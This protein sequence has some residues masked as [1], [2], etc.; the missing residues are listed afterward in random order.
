MKT[1]VYSALV[2]SILVPLSYSQLTW[3]SEIIQCL[4]HHSQINRLILI[5]DKSAPPY[6]HEI[7]RFVSELSPNFPIF[8]LFTN[9]EG[10]LAFLRYRC[11]YV[12]FYTL[13]I[14][15]VAITNK[16]TS[17][18][19]QFIITALFQGLHLHYRTVPNLIALVFYP[20]NISLENI[21]VGFNSTIK[22]LSQTF[23]DPH[24][25][26]LA[27]AATDDS[28]RNSILQSKTQS[29]AKMHIINVF[30]N[31]YTVNNISSVTEIF[32]KTIQNLHNTSLKLQVANLP[33]YLGVELSRERC[34]DPKTLSGPHGLILKSF[35]ESSNFTWQIFHNPGVLRGR[36]SSHINTKCIRKYGLED[37]LV[38]GNIH[39]YMFL[40]M[41]QPFRTHDKGSWFKDIVKTIGYVHVKRN[42][43]LVALVPVFRRKNVSLSENFATL[44]T[45]TVVI[46]IALRIIVYLMKF[47]SGFWRTS[48][49][50]YAIFGINV[51]DTTK[52]TA[53]RF[54]LC[55]MLIISILYSVAIIDQL[56]DVQMDLNREFKL[57]SWADFSEA[58][59]TFKTPILVKNMLLEIENLQ[60]KELLKK[61]VTGKQFRIM[62]KNYFEN[63][64][65]ICIDELMT[66]SYKNVSC[67]MRLSEA[68]SFVRL[69][70]IKYGKARVAVF[71]E[72]ILDMWWSIPVTPLPTY[73]RRFEEV[74]QYLTEAGLVEKWFETEL[75][76]LRDQYNTLNKID[77]NNNQTKSNTIVQLLA[78]LII[79]Y[80]ASLLFFLREILF[81]LTL[82]FQI[83]K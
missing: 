16:T 8:I 54:I 41:P 29:N 48:N 69:S 58:N 25:K 5:I 71:Q 56:F 38:R 14:Y 52:S 82:G 17:K 6:N 23:I 65:E 79:G 39:A 74:I 35:A 19:F 49:I 76:G 4:A 64:N 81:R 11:Q 53:E 18:E 10:D 12:T 50:A 73:V 22:E 28:S 68:E 2:V 36:K 24:I 80:V 37:L 34:P 45:A 9:Y 57:S 59:L 60:L 62:G 15:A 7:Q 77:S 70:A 3:P 1:V 40:M 21:A 47:N 72:S 27:I 30:T 42:E 55:S 43:P 61:A 75:I 33:P 66:K 83:L 20:T 26:M 32:P 44:F 78:I 63:I 51:N 67:I 13:F 31:S 46:I